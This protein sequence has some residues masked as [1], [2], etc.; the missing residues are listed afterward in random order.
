MN[1]ILLS[2]YF[3]LGEQDDIDEVLQPTFIALPSG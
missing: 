1:K 2:S 3:L